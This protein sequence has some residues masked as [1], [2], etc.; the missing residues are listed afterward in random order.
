ME[1][2]NDQVRCVCVCRLL[3]VFTSN[4]KPQ[5]ECVFP[6]AGRMDHAH[7]YNIAARAL[8]EVVRL[9]ECVQAA[10]KL[11]SPSNTLLVVTADHSHT[12]TFGGASVPRGN[13][14]LGSF[15]SSTCHSS[16]NLSPVPLL[17]R[18]SG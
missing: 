11:T 5:C 4:R 6:T 16:L 3:S 7:H 9:D 8:D 14:V 17:D 13:P 10:M 15:F 12:I 18:Q 1:A 2:G